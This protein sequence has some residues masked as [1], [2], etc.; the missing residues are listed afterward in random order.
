ME[1]TVSE[2][3]MKELLKEALTEMMKNDRELFY[4]IVKGAI[5]DVS[6]ANAIK[7]GRKNKFVAEKQVID[8]L[9]EK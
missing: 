1:L 6:L 8:I 9:D 3:K 5:E 4:E 7:E 2:N